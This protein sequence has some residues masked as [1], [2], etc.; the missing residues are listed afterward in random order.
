MKPFVLISTTDKLNKEQLD[1]LGVLLDTTIYG[2]LQY[3]KTR[4]S[5][6][7]VGK[8]SYYENLVNE[9]LKSN[10]WLSL[11]SQEAKEAGVPVIL[12]PDE[13]RASSKLEFLAHA[14]FTYDHEK[15]ELKPCRVS[16]AIGAFIALPA[17][18]HLAQK[19]QATLSLPLD[20]ESCEYWNKAVLQRDLTVSEKILTT[21]P[22]PRVGPDTEFDAKID[23]F[24]QLTLEDPATQTAKLNRRKVIVTPLGI[25][26]YSFLEQLI[27]A[28]NQLRLLKTHPN[29]SDL[30]GHLY[31]R[32]LSGE[33]LSYQEVLQLLRAALRKA[34][35]LIALETYCIGVN[36]HW[37]V[38][39]GTGRETVE[40]FGLEFDWFVLMTEV[41]QFLVL[42]GP[43]LWI[44][45]NRMGPCE[46]SIDVRGPGGPLDLGY[47][48]DPAVLMYSGK[49]VDNRPVFELGD[50][51]L[52]I[53]YCFDGRFNS[54]TQSLELLLRLTTTDNYGQQSVVCTWIPFDPKDYKDSG[55]KGVIVRHWYDEH[56]VSNRSEWL[57][58]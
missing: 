34:M 41:D 53:W 45:K 29:L 55:A 33:E 38:D 8:I 30:H 28:P 10:R 13:G 50:L 21:S 20:A 36:R 7:A 51:S 19:H 3:F 40:F 32:A 15:Q 56:R 1:Q 17:Y 43:S 58:F 2:D 54:E 16:N 39:T 31:Q 4:P 48:Q 37:V 22:Y 47:T 11:Q 9:V 52:P 23:E 12:L 35:N 25:G 14:Y 44:L 49:I 27:G 24:S 18:Q 42:N 26:T 46:K 6:T 57:E 5:V